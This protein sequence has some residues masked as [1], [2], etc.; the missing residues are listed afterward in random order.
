MVCKPEWYKIL[1]MLVHIPTKLL[2]RDVNSSEKALPSRDKTA[3]EGE[4]SD[5]AT[6]ITVGTLIGS[7][8]GYFAAISRSGLPP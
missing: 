7:T 2:L 6:S 8:I 3:V 4:T 1:P 5:G